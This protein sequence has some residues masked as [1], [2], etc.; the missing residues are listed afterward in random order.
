[1]LEVLVVAA[2]LAKV[3]KEAMLAESEKVAAEETLVGVETL[4]EGDLVM[5][6][7]QAAPMMGHSIPLAYFQQVYTVPGAHNNS[8]SL[9]NRYSN[10]SNHSR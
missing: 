2:Q 10:S 1:V 3:V 7:A 6:L 4:V 5:I 9:R 8:M